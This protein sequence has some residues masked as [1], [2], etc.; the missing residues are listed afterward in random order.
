MTSDK[1][2]LVVQ[3]NLYTAAISM[4]FADPSYQPSDITALNFGDM[5]STFIV[6]MVLLLQ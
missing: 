4:A 1:V 2:S 6:N 5:L 3:K